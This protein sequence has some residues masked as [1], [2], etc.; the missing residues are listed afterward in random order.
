MP[1]GRPGQRGRGRPPLQRNVYSFEDP[2]LPV[3]SEVVLDPSFV[4]EALV[5]TEASTPPARPS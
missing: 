5:T 1:A 4:I 2:D 3:P